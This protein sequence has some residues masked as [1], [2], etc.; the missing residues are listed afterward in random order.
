M[1]SEVFVN[2]YNESTEIPILSRYLYRGV[3]DEIAR[4]PR[5]LSESEIIPFEPVRVM[6]GRKVRGE[7][8]MC[9]ACAPECLH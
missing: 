8:L 7:M 6:P 9:Q 1:E 4:F 2:L 5:E 3:S